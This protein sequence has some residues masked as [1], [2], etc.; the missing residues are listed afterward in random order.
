MSKKVWLI[1]AGLLSVSGIIA[2]KK[3]EEVADTLERWS[4]GHI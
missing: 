1:A 2:Y 3:R 4:K